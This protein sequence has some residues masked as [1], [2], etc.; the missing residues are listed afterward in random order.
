[1]IAKHTSNSNVTGSLLSSRSKALTSTIDLFN[2]SFCLDG[3]FN[4]I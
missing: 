2:V 1:M 4:V 3:K